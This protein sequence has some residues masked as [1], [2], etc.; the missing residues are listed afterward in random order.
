M[1]AYRLVHQRLRERRLVAFVVPVAP[2]AK[3]IDDDGMLEF[4]PELGRNLGS[5]HHCLRVVAVGVKDRRL[6]HLCNVG[7]VRR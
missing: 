7:R 5:K 2:V 4:L 6:D 3:H 1:I